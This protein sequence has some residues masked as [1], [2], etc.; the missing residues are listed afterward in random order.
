MK[1]LD[2]CSNAARIATSEF[3]SPG[4]HRVSVK[5]Y[6]SALPAELGVIAFLLLMAASTIAL[7]NSLSLTGGLASPALMGWLKS[8]TGH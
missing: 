8:M 7:I 4:L 3:L 1:Y 2:G 5:L 6:E